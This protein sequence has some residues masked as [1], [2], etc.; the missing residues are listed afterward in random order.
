MLDS[1]QII[2][3]QNN[4]IETK[5]GEEMY[6]IAICDDDQVIGASIE[7]IILN[8]GKNEGLEFETDVYYHGK[9]LIRVFEQGSYYDL[10]FLDIELGD[11]SGIEI[12]KWLRNHMKHDSAHIIYISAHSSYALELFKTRPFDFLIKPFNEQDV[13]ADLKKSMELSD[14]QGKIF[15][16]KKGW[17]TY[18]IPIRDI[19]YFKC[20]NKEVEIHTTE[21]IEVF[22]SSL[23]KVYEKLGKW[24]FFYCHQ[25]FLV[26]YNQVAEFRYEQLKMRNGEIL[27]I[28][29]GKRKQVRYMLQEFAKEDL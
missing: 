8:Y 24:R 6:R 20:S 2:I 12:G 21:G 26:N 10:L 16:Y 14:Y 4:K 19:L 17:E 13:L 22:Y 15:T 25:S 9:E 3:L 7:K 28:S 23:E 1:Q 29:Q 5:S 18:K 11:I 27:G